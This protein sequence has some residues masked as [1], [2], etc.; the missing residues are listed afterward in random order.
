MAEFIRA[1][2]RASASL[3]VCLEPLLGRRPRRQ[4][5]TGRD[6]YPALL[7]APVLLV[8]LERKDE[9]AL[10]L[11][12]RR[13]AIVGAILHAEEGRLRAV[14]LAPAFAEDDAELVDA[15]VEEA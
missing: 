7:G 1:I 10:A 9:H 14:E 4:R 5:R 3:P 6:L 8:P 12:E 15:L 11:A 13:L 2:S